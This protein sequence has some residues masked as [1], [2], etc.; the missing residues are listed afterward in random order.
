MQFLLQKWGIQT[1]SALN[2]LEAVNKALNNDYDAILM[3]VQM[4]IMDGHQATEKIR[5]NSLKLPIVALTAHVVKEERD[6][7]AR[8]GFT[9]F[10]PKPV[11]KNTLRDLLAG[12]FGT[13]ENLPQHIM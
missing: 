12:Y 10:L 7:C 5:A 8:S 1:D 2:G 13:K 6:L 3:D 4:P 11:Q 9:D